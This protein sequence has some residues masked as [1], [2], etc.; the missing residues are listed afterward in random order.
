MENMRP[1]AFITALIFVGLLLAACGAGG[2]SPASSGTPDD[3]TLGEGGATV[4]PEAEDY[5]IVTLLPK[6]AIPSI[7]NPQFYSAEEAD[8][9]YAPNELVIGVE[10]DGEARAY[11]IHLLSSHEIVNDV[12]AGRPIAVTW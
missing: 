7:D 1:L 12:V 10:F 9:E 2:T 4:A 8:E 3:E 11:S 5:E 6:D